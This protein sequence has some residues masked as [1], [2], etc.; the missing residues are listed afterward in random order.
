MK[1]GIICCQIIVVVLQ[2]KNDIKIGR[3]KK[4]VPN[5]D[6]KS[7]CVLHYRN[8]QL[9]LSLRMKLVS[10]R[11]VL[12][13]KQYDWL[14]KYIDFKTDKRKIA[15]NSFEKCFFKLMNNGVYGKTMENLRKI[16]IFRLV[17]NAKDYK[18]M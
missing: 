18:N 13:F 6:N 7:K 5:L 3:V 11:R 9:Y 10:I 2:K 16:I 8:L 1:L 15:A 17:N 14:K 12:K 4:L